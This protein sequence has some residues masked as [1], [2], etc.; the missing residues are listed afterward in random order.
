MTVLFK[1]ILI[2]FLISV[3]VGPIAVLCI[4]RALAGSRR[5]GFISGLGA[6]TADSAYAALA[7]LGLTFVSDVLLPHRRL[8]GLCGGVA[9]ILLGIKTF[10]KPGKRRALHNTITAHAGNFFSTFILT[11]LNPITVLAFFAI[12]SAYGLEACQHDQGVLLV[13]GVF[14]G[15]CLWWVTLSALAGA[16][17]PWMDNDHLTLINRIA[18]TIIVLFGLGVILKSLMMSQF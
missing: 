13:G 10:I 1:G 6:A 11:L 16:L 12:F 18:G 9:L 7:V 15:A 3:P 5:H 4:Q 2:G 14:T 8:L 17:R